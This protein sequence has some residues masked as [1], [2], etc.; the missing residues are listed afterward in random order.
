MKMILTLKRDDDDDDDEGG[1]K[2]GRLPQRRES[3]QKSIT[4][5]AGSL[6][7]DEDCN[8]GDDARIGIMMMMSL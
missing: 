7:H 1:Q 8:D 3:H 6:Y 4:A 5:Q 2:G